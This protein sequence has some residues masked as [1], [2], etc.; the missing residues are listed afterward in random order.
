MCSMAVTQDTRIVQRAAVTPPARR[1]LRDSPDPPPLPVL[2]PQG[3]AS[4]WPPQ[5][6]GPKYTHVSRGNTRRDACESLAS[7]A[8]PSRRMVTAFGLWRDGRLC[9]TMLGLGSPWRGALGTCGWGHWGLRGWWDA[10]AHWMLAGHLPKPNL[11]GIAKYKSGAT[12]YNSLNR[13]KLHVKNQ[14][15][16]K[17]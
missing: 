16:L 7:G 14:G 1:E 3:G 9:P 2:H 12:Q 4:R 10:V 6:L 15:A 13:G 8:S 11:A 17:S 5:L